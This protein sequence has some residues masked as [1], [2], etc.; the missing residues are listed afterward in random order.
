MS[1][2]IQTY[3]NYLSDLKS[4]L[5]S[6]DM[7]ELDAATHVLAKAYEEGRTVYVAGNGGSASTA[8]HLACDFSKTTQNRSHESGRKRLRGIA[9]SDNVPLITAYGNDISY[10]HVFS[11]Q[12]RTLASPG[13]VLIVITASG[14]SPSV[15]KA[16]EVAKEME[17]TSIAFLGFKGGKCRGLSDHSILAESQSYGIIEDAHSVLMHMLTEHLK[18][19]VSSSSP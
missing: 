8:S 19:L 15:V 11:E 7:N 16:L 12:L 17:L 4:V 18:E 13:D 9:L 2:H 5:D 6:L 3:K 1:R 10:D 14:N